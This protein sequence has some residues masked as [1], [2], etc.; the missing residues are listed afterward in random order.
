[1]KELVKTPF[2]TA[3]LTKAAGPDVDLNKLHVFE[4]RAT[5]TVPLRGKKG[6]IFERATISPHT[7]SLLAKSV[8]EDAVPLMMDHELDGAPYGKFFYAESVPMESGDIELRGY[9]YVDDSEEV[10]LTKLET[11]SIDEVSIQFL[12]SHMLCSECGF[13]YFEAA[14]NDNFLPLMSHTCEQ[15]HVIGREG[16][17]VRLVGVEEM[18]ELSLVSRGAA[19]NSKIIG[20]SDAMLGESAQRLAASGVDVRNDYY[21]TASINDEGVNDVDFKDLTAK[22]TA[23]TDDKIDLATKL[24]AAEAQVTALTSDRD[25]EKARA[26]SAEAQV[27]KL[28]EAAATASQEAEGV[29]TSETV[30][31]MSALI[32]KNYVAL[33]ALDG[34]ADANV[35]EDITEAV[36]FI[37]DN[38]ARLSALIPAGGVTVQAGGSQGNLTEGQKKLQ[39]AQVSAFK[40]N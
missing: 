40:S 27:T 3:L 23:L 31:A 4:V 28:T 9:I 18:I 35:P 11:G 38:Q 14:A 16:V 21:C 29:P 19:K 8:N 10:I 2:I 37:E 12:S 7:I 20:S 5:S 34:E 22:L 24:V 15:G 26:D 13:D 6:T 39:I 32:G 25:S 30:T 1:M 36:K 17:H 33:K